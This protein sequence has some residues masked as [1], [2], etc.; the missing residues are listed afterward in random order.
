MV[1]ELAN[2]RLTDLWPKPGQRLILVDNDLRW[3]LD[4]PHRSRAG[5]I[6]LWAVVRASTWWGGF[7]PLER[8]TLATFMAI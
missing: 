1:D 3:E 2:V 5:A 8:L 6:R 7:D 4:P